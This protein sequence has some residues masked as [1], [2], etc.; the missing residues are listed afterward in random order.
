[1]AAQ[2]E[3]KLIAEGREAEIFAWENGTVLRLLRNPE[4]AQQVEW[5]AHAMQAAA[6]TGVSVPA[7][8][9]TTIVRGRPGLIMERIDGIDML[10]LIGRKPWRIFD[11]ARVFGEM[12][13]QLH[14]TVA[15]DEILPLNAMLK[16]RIESSGMVPKHVAEFALGELEQ[17]PQ[18]DRL[19]HGDF[20]PGNIMWAGEKPVVIDWTN[21]MRGDP[22]AD[23]ARS[24]LMI[25]LGDLPPGSSLPLRL[26]TL[27]GRAALRWSYRR[28]YR[29]A[30]PVDERLVARWEIPVAANRLVDGI[31]PERPKLLRILEARLKSG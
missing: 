8:H 30:R 20:H 6:A 28:A 7:V 23:Y 2:P 18:G 5:E 21:V 3:L 29:K 25:R 15:P 24:D 19:C 14:E 10:T 26:L 11:V 16:R 1:M 13:A 31:E 22:T 4:A 9:G 12:Q 27:V 17:L